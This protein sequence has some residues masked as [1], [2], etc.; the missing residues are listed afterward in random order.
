M[1]SLHYD[2][3]P[4]AEGGP[5]LFIAV[6]TYKE[7]DT[8]TAFALARAREALT[9]AG[10]KS[11]LHI[12]EGNCHVDD[13]R[14]AIVHDFL[15]ESDC[16]DLMF[17]DADVTAEPECFVQLAQRDRDIVLGVYPYRREGG[18]TMPV[19]LKPGAEID[20]DGLLEIEGGPTGFM[21]IKR[22]VLETMAAEAPKYWD[23]IY[24]TPLV[25]TRRIGEG[26]TRWGGDIDFC[27]RWRA[28]GGKIYADA[29]LRLGHVGKVIVRDSLAASLRRATGATLSRIIP[30]IK[31][32][33]HTFGD[34]N[35]VFRYASNP[36]AADPETLS[37]VTGIARQAGPMWDREGRGH[38]IETGSGLSSVLMGA[39]LPVGFKVYA[40]EHLS[41]FA[42]QTVQWC[43]ESGVEN[44]GV[45]CAP[46]K[47]WWYDVGAFDLPDR[48]ALGFCDGPPRLYGTRMRFFD[49]IAPRCS[50]IV[51]DDFKTDN[52]FARKVYEWADANGRAVQV[53]GRA[54]LLTKV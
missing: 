35:E 3:G 5:K 22:H 27:N 13:A 17:L 14:N 45:H 30:R 2:E 24:L 34:F 9:A 36:Y 11:A 51:V 52:A 10:I 21:K 37:L 7:P 38:V 6:P 49:V 42:A 40:L 1:S 18:E 25:F 44:V 53:L 48:F 41:H 16:T 15:N 43:E 28:M 23:K 46:L 54:A 50:V 39:V 8:A 31:A 47:D 20:A 12:L 4:P 26:N 19:R 32:R 29:E 33:T